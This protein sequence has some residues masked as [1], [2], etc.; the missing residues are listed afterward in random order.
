MLEMKDERFDAPLS[1]KVGQ[2]ITEHSFMKSANQVS[3]SHERSVVHK[4]PRKSRKSGSC[5]AISIL[6]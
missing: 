3:D 4:N 1:L 5:G 2:G 6:G